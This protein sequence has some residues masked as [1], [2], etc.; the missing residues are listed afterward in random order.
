M[1][2]SVTKSTKF[3]LDMF[4]KE[5]SEI[6]SCHPSTFYKRVEELKNYYIYQDG[7][8]HYFDSFTEVK[9]LNKETFI[10]TRN[11]VSSIFFK[12]YD[13]IIYYFVDH[14]RNEDLLLVMKFGHKNAETN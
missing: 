3:S 5:F 13:S 1:Q 12:E 7:L 6:Y 11:F 10:N 2:I 14:P 9:K 8:I 4:A